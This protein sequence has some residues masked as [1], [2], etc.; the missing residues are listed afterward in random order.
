MGIVVV[1]SV[2]FDDVITPFGKNLNAPGGSATFFS[3]SAS[4]F[5]KVKLVAVVGNDFPKKYIRLLE[6]KGVDTEGLRI[7]KGKTF[8]WKGRYSWDLNTAETLKLQLNLFQDFSP[9]LPE[10]YRDEDMLFLANIDPDLQLKVLKQVHSPKLIA[11]DTIDYWIEHKRKSLL[12]VLKKIDILII[13]E[14]EARKLT[15]ESNLCKAGKRIISYGPGSVVIKKG[16]HGVMLVS[17][18]GIFAY[19]AFPLDDVCDP[20][21]A[22]DTFAGGFLGYLSGL[23]SINEAAIRRALVY[24]NIMASF[25]VEGYDIKVLSKLNRAKIDKRVK[26]FRRVCSF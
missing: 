26:A 6:K 7:E 8:R 11:A 10:D 4:Y 21:G 18:E 13:N 14:A 17:K 23:K 5:T 1:G 3:L 19:P 24:G 20:T 22:G 25:N 2:A 16:E 9:E 12:K 15:K